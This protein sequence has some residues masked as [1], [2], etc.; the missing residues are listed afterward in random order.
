MSRTGTNRLSD[1]RR[2]VHATAHAN[3]GTLF[4]DTLSQPQRNRN[5]PTLS[6]ARSACHRQLSIHLP[7]PMQLHPRA[8]RRSIAHR[9]TRTVSQEPS[10]KNRVTRTVSQEPSHKN[11]LTRTDTNTQ[12]RTGF[13]AV[14]HV[15]A[16]GLDS[17]A[18][19]VARPLEAVNRTPCTSIPHSHDTIGSRCYNLGTHTNNSASG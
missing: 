13:T 2:Y 16:V 4:D 15:D 1:N 19:C 9:L 6:V 10:H 12:Q 8:R 17:L 18:T 5:A 7:S 3:N 14:A 11:R